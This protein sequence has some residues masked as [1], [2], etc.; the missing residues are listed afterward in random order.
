MKDKIFKRSAKKVHF[1]LT[2]NYYALRIFGAYYELITTQNLHY[3]DI[4][5]NCSA[6]ISLY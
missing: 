1:G 2:Q 4:H 6:L 3:S 5:R